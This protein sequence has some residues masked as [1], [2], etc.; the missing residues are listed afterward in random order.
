MIRSNPLGRAPRRKSVTDAVPSLW[1]AGKGT[2]T[3]LRHP[4]TGGLL[5]MPQMGSGGKGRT[6]D[7][8]LR[9]SSATQVTCG[10]C[11]KLMSINHDLRDDD[12]SVG[13][14]DILLS[15]A[16]LRRRG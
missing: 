2:R 14:P 12:L 3:H 1:T 9:P 16:R 10:R 13:T 8:N 5:C 7:G 6:R 15:A 4:E 11:I